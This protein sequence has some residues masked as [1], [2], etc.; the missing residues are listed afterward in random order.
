[1]GWTENGGRR[2]RPGMAGGGGG[3]C[4]LRETPEN[5]AM[6]WGVILGIQTTGRGEWGVPATRGKKSGKP[7]YEKKKE[8]IY[9]TGI[10]PTPPLQKTPFT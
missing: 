8:R 4:R 2:W 3:G 9:D 6:H 10:S 1:M 7:F 5:G